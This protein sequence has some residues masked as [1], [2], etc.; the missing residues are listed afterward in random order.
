MSHRK[1]LTLCWMLCVLGLVGCG[2]SSG[3][4]RAAVDI[5]VLKL[6][7]D[8]ALAVVIFKNLSQL[9]EKL[10]QLGQKAGL[11]LPPNMLAMAHEKM[12]LKDGLDDKG[13]VVLAVLPG[14]GPLD[15]APPSAV[16]FLPV[17]DYDKFI[18]QLDPQKGS[19]GVSQIQFG[20][21]PRSPVAKKGNY[22]AIAPPMNE[23]ALKSALSSKAD[24]SSELASVSGWLAD[25]DIAAVATTAGIKA[26]VG[27]AR[28]GLQKVKK[29][30]PPDNPQFGNVA[31]AFDMYD[32][33][34]KACD[35]ELTHIGI[36]LK[37]DKDSNVHITS[38]W[39]I[40][41][42]GSLANALAGVKSLTE[43]PLADLPAG[44]FVFAMSGVVP[45]GMAHGSAAMMKFSPQTAGL[46]EE[47][48]RK[49]E[50]MMVEM[51]KGMGSMSFVMGVPGDHDAMF[52]NSIAT[53]H[54]ENAPKYLETLLPKM[55]EM[56]QV[57][58]ALKIP[59]ADNFEAKALEVN[60]AKAIEFTMDLSASLPP[61]AD[62]NAKRISD[63][64]MAVMMG[65]GGKMTL[66]Y[67]AAD[68]KTIVA[69]YTGGEDAQKKL[70]AYKNRSGS[71]ASDAQTAKALALLPHDAQMV[72][73]WDVPGTLSMVKQIMAKFAP[74]APSA[75]IPT[76]PAMPPIGFAA[77]VSAQ[78]VDTDLVVPVETIKA[79]AK[80]AQDAMMHKKADA[81]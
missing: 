44:P 29:S 2:G 32:A 74:D 20:P 12:G 49:L 48:S 27:P 30:L 43:K 10:T 45:E 79:I 41:T 54:V 57:Y 71:L 19:D 62:E 61:A 60:G 17:T 69:C 50:A 31:A 34:F 56:K 70:A 33:L 47:Q 64:M 37:A 28:E 72:A 22:A 80:T 13:S 76:L 8:N 36:G 66:T 67:I 38:H 21:G 15:K 3:G 18:A 51:M 46:T 68:D 39:G 6:V 40:K 65:P 5:P 77:T 73:V 35:E 11:P 24:I 59:G 26:A 53:M 7:P 4:P 9:D 78:S 25:Q 14:E 42:G 81:P 16:L 1:S 52:Q 63:A 55:Q 23:G 75:M 58:Q